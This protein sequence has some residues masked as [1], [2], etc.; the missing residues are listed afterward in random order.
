MRFFNKKRGLIIL[1]TLLLLLLLFLLFRNIREGNRESM[2]DTESPSDAPI[3]VGEW[4][5]RGVDM[6]N[7]KNK[8]IS[9]ENLDKDG[10]MRKEERQKEST[11]W[12]HPGA[13]DE[14][15]RYHYNKKHGKEEGAQPVTTMRYYRQNNRQNN[16][17]NNRQNNRRNN[18]R[19]N[20]QGSGPPEPMRTQNRRGSGPP[21]PMGGRR[22]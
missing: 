8:R 16:R 22:P 12:K 11:K 1:F 13:I 15:K 3:T 20:R 18:R 10:R 7:E 6:K 2:S 14:Y 17:R 4:K 9:A 21:E 5:N 19:N